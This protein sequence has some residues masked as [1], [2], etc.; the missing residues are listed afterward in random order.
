MLTSLLI[1][2]NWANEILLIVIY[3][4]KRLIFTLKLDKL[5]LYSGSDFSKFFI[6]GF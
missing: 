4:K 5:N 1:N 3:L 2:K 6:C